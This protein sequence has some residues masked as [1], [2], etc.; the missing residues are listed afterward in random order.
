MLARG[1]SST[2]EDRC[3]MNLGLHP[4]VIDRPHRVAALSEFI[5]CVKG[6]SPVW[7]PNCQEIAT[8]YLAK[9]GQRVTRPS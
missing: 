2:R 4:H 7:F 5:E 9:R 1:S 3:I 6:K 8:W